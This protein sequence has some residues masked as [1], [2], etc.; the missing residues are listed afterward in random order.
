MPEKLKPCPLCGGKRVG[1]L[2]PLSGRGR[3]WNVF[4]DGCGLVLFGDS[5]ESRRVMVERWN[6]R[7]DAA[8]GE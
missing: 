1:S 7:A 2:Q 8:G 6:N 3:P 4:C 5:G